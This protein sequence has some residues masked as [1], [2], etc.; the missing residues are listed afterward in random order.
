MQDKDRVVIVGGGVVG[1]CAAY[2]LLCAGHPVRVVEK[3]GADDPNCSTGNAGMVVPSHFVPLAAPG[4]IGKGLRW[5]FNRES[6]FCVR[7]RPGADLLRWGWLFYRHANAAHVARSR[8]LLRDLNL[9]SRRLFAELAAEEDFGLEQRGLLML[10]RTAEALDEEGELAA[11]AGEIGLEARV[12]DQR[13]VAGLDPDVTMD[14][15]GAVYFPQDC[16]LDPDRFLAVLRRRVIA[17]GGE[18]FG[19]SEVE[20]FEFADGRVVAA[21]AG[22]ARHDGGHFVVAGGVWSPALL[23][24][25]GMWLPMQAGKG[26][27]LTLQQPAELPRLCSIFVEAKVAVT[28]LGGDLRFAG[29]MEVGADDLRIDRAR[30]RGIVNSVPAYFPKFRREDFAG[31][32]PWVGLRPVS[33]DGLP[34]IGRAPGIRNLVVATGH[35]MMGLSLGPVSGQLVANLIGGR[36]PFRPIGQLDPARF[37]S[38]GSGSR[39]PA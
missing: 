4:M 22:G 19:S 35:A 3:G 8:E 18:M 14:I 25:L 17:M 27:S 2:H 9:E 34:Y 11:Q 30:V 23:R 12:L 39:I 10:C 7:L 28:P 38:S 24:Q 33:P 13:E 36:E 21:R 26:Y 15:R 1:L 32:E 20:G 31:I 6:P 37:G 16:H 5:M 29:T